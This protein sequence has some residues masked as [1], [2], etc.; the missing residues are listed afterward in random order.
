MG[1]G[2]C[3]DLD[4]LM[5]EGKFSR[6]KESFDF[7]TCNSVFVLIEN[8]LAA[9]KGWK[10]YLK[11]GGRII[12]D[13]PTERTAPEGLIFE[14]IAVELRMKSPSRRLWVKDQSSLRQLFVDGG[15]YIERAW[16]APGYDPGM[17]YKRMR[18]ESCS[19]SGRL[20]QRTLRLSL[21]RALESWRGGRS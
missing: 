7:I 13:V 10:R 20:G 3:W 11:V 5:K 12:V 16:R 21:R 18:L 14:G 2:R 1:G 8:P 15:H 9:L 4:G 19:T 17:K 6:P